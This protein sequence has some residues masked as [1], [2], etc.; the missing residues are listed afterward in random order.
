MK[1]MNSDQHKL[2]P[3]IVIKD[4]IKGDGAGRGGSAGKLF[5]EQVWGQNL[6]TQNPYKSQHDGEHLEPQHWPGVQRPQDSESS[7]ASQFSLM[8]GP[9]SVRDFASK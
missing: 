1:V 8:G 7:L 6:A 2:K 3:K 4:C 5:D 9:G